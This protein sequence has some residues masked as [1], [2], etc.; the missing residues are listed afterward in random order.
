MFNR[1]L[2]VSVNHQ[3]E[4]AI[5][6]SFLKCSLKLISGN[7][8]KKWIWTEDRPLFSIL[9]H[10][11]YR[12]WI[13]ENE[14]LGLKLS[15]ISLTFFLTFQIL[16]MICFGTDFFLFI[17][18]GVFYIPWSSKYVA[19]IKFGKFWPLFFQIFFFSPIFFLVWDSVNVYVRSFSIVLLVSEALFILLFRLFYFH[20]PNWVI[21][22]VLSSKFFLL[23][24]GISYL[25]HEVRVVFFLILVIVI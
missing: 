19:F 23:L 18:L 3:Q 16:I 20:C 6:G 22:I 10:N 1:I 24:S 2:L 7:K 21:F 9:V 15:K 5:G 17:L 12:A 8:W 14:V 4:S 13:P 11:R 25:A